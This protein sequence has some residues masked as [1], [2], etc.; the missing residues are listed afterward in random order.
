MGLPQDNLDRLLDCWQGPR[1][2]RDL[3]ARILAR[4]AAE[5]Q[6][7]DGLVLLADPMPALKRDLTPAILAKVAEENRVLD[8]LLAKAD[9]KPVLAGDLTGRI[10][11]RAR[12]EETELDRALATVET[13]P[14][15]QADVSRRVLATVRR[16]RMRR[17]IVAWAGSLSAAAAVAIVALLLRHGLAPHGQPASP[18]AQAVV[19]AADVDVVNNLD[20]ADLAEDLPVLKNWD[21]IR[22]MEQLDQERQTETASSTIKR[23]DGTWFPCER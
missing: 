4:T 2:E 20:L 14:A 9:P 5:E 22:A 12:R 11:A 16:E 8:E 7:L 23:L 17:R 10:L 6:A 21:T 15:M 3:A 18:T 19:A 13:V 1:L